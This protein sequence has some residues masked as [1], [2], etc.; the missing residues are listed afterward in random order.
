ME[1]HVWGLPVTSSMTSSPWKYFFLHN[2]GGSF[3][4]WCQIEAA[5]NVRKKIKWR[6]LRAGVNF[7]AGSVTRSWAH[8]QKSQEHAVHF[9]LLIDVLAQKVMVLWHFQ[10]LTYFVISWPSYSTYILVQRTCR[11]HELVLACDQVWWWLTDSFLRFCEIS[12]QTD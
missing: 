3:N 8:W 5:L 6:N 4:I 2:F 10:N 9:E 11:N 1:G 7:F 12:V